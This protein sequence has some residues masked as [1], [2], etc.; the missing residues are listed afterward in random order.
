MAFA[1]SPCHQRAFLYE[2][3]HT[4]CNYLTYWVWSHWQNTVWVIEL[5]KRAQIAPLHLSMPH[6]KKGTNMESLKTTS[7]KASSS[8]IIYIYIYTVIL[9][10]GSNSIGTLCSCISLWFMT[11]V[12][13]L[14][15]SKCW[16]NDAKKW[17]HLLKKRLGYV[18]NPHFPKERNR[19]VT[20]G[21]RQFRN[22]ARDRSVHFE[23]K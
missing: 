6:K 19:D 11:S 7:K 12:K 18:C 9:A 23:S 13:A 10:N 3:Y 4:F 1:A 16:C 14:N 5:G 20:L 21:V 2:K 22:L 15:R 17:A 8:F